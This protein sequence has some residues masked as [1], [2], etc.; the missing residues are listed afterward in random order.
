MKW[1]QAHYDTVLLVAAAILSLTLCGIVA[2]WTLD[3]PADFAQRNSSA[4]RN[5]EVRDASHGVLTDAIDYL[6]KP[7]LWGGHDG[8][9]FASRIYVLTKGT[10]IDPIEGETPLHAP[11]PNEWLLK[12]DLDYSQTDILDSDPDGDGFTV[13]EEWRAGSDPTDIDS[14]PPF[15]TKLRLEEF[16]RI[17]FKVK[18][19]G[20]PDGGETF[21]INFIDDRTMPTQFVK[22]GDT[23]NIASL[24]YR[25]SKFEEKRKGESEFFRDVS[26]LTLESVG[27]G[28]KIIL[29]HDTTVDSPTMFGIFVNLLDGERIKVKRGDTFQMSQAPDTKYRLNEVTDTQA[30]VVDESSGKAHVIPTE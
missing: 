28:E 8:S 9:L 24:P 11:V 6:G 15:W 2:L 30:T 25:V 27:S 12:F 21:T 19:S 13:L 16:E 29:I 10:L 5:N 26:E 4:P 17:P 20:S 14:V 22:L 1:F 18:F 7:S 3:F 23:V